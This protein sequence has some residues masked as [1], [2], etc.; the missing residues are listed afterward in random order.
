MSYNL[1][2]TLQEEE[3][4]EGEGHRAN[5]INT[6]AEVFE[7]EREV[8]IAELQ[9]SVVEAGIEARNAEAAYDAPTL[10]PME[11]KLE[12]LQRKFQEQVGVSVESC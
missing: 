11:Q 1:T 6:V 3:I 9:T 2:L 7:K 4:L 10:E 5:L 12:A 8:L